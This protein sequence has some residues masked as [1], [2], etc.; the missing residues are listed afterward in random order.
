M[1][2]ILIMIVIVITIFVEYMILTGNYDP[3]NN[4]YEKLPTVV[5]D[6]MVKK[7]KRCKMDGT[8]LDYMGRPL[9]SDAIDCTKCIRYM[10]KD[11][12][13]YCTSMQYDGAGCS[14]F[15]AARPCPKKV[16]D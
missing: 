10:S 8:F 16:T 4:L 2:I 3:L 9:S 11:D 12:D 15:G 13:G 14:T 1:R 5:K 6:S 7:G